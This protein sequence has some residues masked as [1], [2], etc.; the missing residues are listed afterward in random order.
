MFR[1]TTPPWEVI[2]FATDKR[3]TYERAGEL[4]LDHPWSYYPEGIAD[5]ARLECRYPVILKPTVRQH[6]NAFTAAKAWRIDSHE[7]LMARYAQA[8]ALVGRDAIVLQEMVPGNGQAQFSYAAVW[9]ENGPVASLIA[10]RARQ[11][12]INFGYTST[13]VHSI[14]HAGIEEAAIRFLRSI[15]YTGMVEIEFKYDERDLKYKILDVNARTWTWQALGR[16]AGVDFAHIM[17][18]V[19]M[20]EQVPETRGHAG[21]AW[22]HFSRDVIAAMQEIFIGRLKLRDYLKSLR[23]PT[24]YAAYAQDDPMPGLV[25]LPIMMGR[26]AKRRR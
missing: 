1:V 7:E 2:R 3:L 4:G 26:L 6:V 14:E 8:E 13:F 10:K 12:P 15:H 23:M 22:M 18:R 21:V 19:A 16:L 20:G 9:N 17:Y 5:V 25:D 11:Y 24:E